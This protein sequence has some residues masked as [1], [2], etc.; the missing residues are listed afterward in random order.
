M[1]MTREEYEG[2]ADHVI[3]NSGP[4]AVLTENV[5]NLLTGELGKRGIRL[6]GGDQETMQ[7]DIEAK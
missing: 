4:L 7:S 2:L 5:R 6:R 3:D 1:Q